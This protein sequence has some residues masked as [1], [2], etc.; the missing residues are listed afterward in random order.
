MESVQND[1][2]GRIQSGNVGSY[3]KYGIILVAVKILR[4]V[5]LFECY[6]ILKT[7]H[8]VQFL[9][10]VKLICSGVYLLIHKPFSSGR[11]LNKRQWS[12][13]FRHSVLGL[14]NNVLWLFSL[15]LCGP[16][17]TVLVFEHGEHVLVSMF[18]G[19]FAGRKGNYAKT[20][21]SLLFFLGVLCLLLFDNDDML[22]KILSQPEGQHTSSI[23]H[24]LSAMISFM[25]VADHKGGVLLLCLTL[26]LKV[27]LNG[28]TKRVTTHV[29]G[30][31]RLHAFST[32]ISTLLLLPWASLLYFTGYSFNLF[33]NL[34]SVV[35]IATTV[36]IV[37][38]YGHFFVSNKL[39]PM[40]VSRLGYFAI[41]GTAMFL[42]FQWSHPAIRVISN[43]NGKMDSVRTE[44]HVISGGVIVSMVFFIL[45][46]DI[47]SWPQPK[48]QKGSFIGYSAE[49]LPLYRFAGDVLNRASKTSFGTLVNGFLRRVLEEKDS[50]HIFYF[51]CINLS[52]AFVELAWGAWSNS[53]GLISDSFHMLFDCTA[54]VLG[55]VA[56][57]MAKWKSTRIFPYGYGRVEVLSGFVN[58]LFLL[59]V[60]FFL[61]YEAF[62]RL[63]DPPAINTDKLLY[64]SVGGLLVNLIGVFVFSHQHHHNHGH[65]HGYNHHDGHENCHSH[66][67]S[68]AN[69]KGVYLHVL[70][71]LLGSIGVIISS[72]MVSKWQL[73]IA[74]PICTLAVASLIL[75]TVKPLL[76]DSARVLALCA[77]PHLQKTLQQALSKV[78]AIEGVTAHRT[79]RVW[80]HTEKE[81]AAVV[82]VHVEPHVIEQRIISQ[83]TSIF[84][85]AGISSVTVQ[86]E[87]DDFYQHMSGLMTGTD[88]MTQISRGISLNQSSDSEG[89]F[90]KLI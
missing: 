23:T 33:S 25:G 85:E 9:F 32:L 8:L 5:G 78:N 46:S 31:K 55:L 20:R 17:R 4:C 62:Q 36:F 77:P 50:R 53:L 43:V 18:M 6:D 73:L 38:H 83:V 76:R 90:T 40:Q 57:V 80:Q 82:S 60:A 49:G 68:D 81:A 1:D 58:G 72:L 65:S 88:D 7:I 45:A 28:Y 67:H 66:S 30:A 27:A 61:F 84:K 63:I 16:L 47:L 52:F 56:A 35:F 3:G 41:A 70:A 10:L 37:E 13:V 26:L 19:V 42:G 89:E 54:L 71:D 34:F 51:L 2:F 74:D 11:K 69:I 15:T 59:V 39:S 12:Y 75:C 14:L 22:S 64:V 87:K 24:Y 44:E 79:C 21:G 86:V 48:S 29:G